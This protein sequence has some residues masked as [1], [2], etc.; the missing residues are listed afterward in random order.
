MPIALS[1]SHEEQLVTAIAEGEVGREDI[2]RYLT[3]VIADKAMPYRKLFNLTFAPVA[4]SVADLRALGKRVA[5]HAKVG[6]VG[7]V[8]IVVG[9]ELAHE[10]AKIFD[11]QARASRELRIFRDLRAAQEWLD[12]M[13]PPS[14]LGRSAVG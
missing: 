5:E 10:M 2:D 6:P 12:E 1:I 14:S 3:A 9:S 4:L 13:A 7:P 11:E 8:A